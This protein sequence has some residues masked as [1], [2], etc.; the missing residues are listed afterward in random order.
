MDLKFETKDNQI[1]SGID[2]YFE[3]TQEGQLDYMVYTT[4]L[5]TSNLSNSNDVLRRIF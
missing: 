1:L 4:L 2:Y 5:Y 3:P